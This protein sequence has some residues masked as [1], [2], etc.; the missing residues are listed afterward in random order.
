MRG[1]MVQGEV[2]AR[3][4]FGS[5]RVAGRTIAEIHGLLTDVCAVDADEACTLDRSLART[6]SDISG[7]LK[8]LEGHYG[9]VESAHGCFSAMRSFKSYDMQ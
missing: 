1:V 5:L 9:I 4:P 8:M 3:I 6:T 2:T 7:I